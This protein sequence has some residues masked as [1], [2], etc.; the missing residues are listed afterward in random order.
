MNVRGIIYLERRQF[1]MSVNVTK[2]KD[3][4]KSCQDDETMGGRHVMMSNK[5]FKLSLTTFLI[6]KIDDTL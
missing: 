1:Y 6:S 4:A 3:L 2:K 5:T